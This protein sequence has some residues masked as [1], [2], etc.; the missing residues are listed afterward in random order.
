MTNQQYIRK[1]ALIYERYKDEFDKVSEQELYDFRSEI[2]KAYN[3]IPLREIKVLFVD[4]DPY[5]TVAEL[6]ADVKINKVMRVFSGG[7]NSK[8]LPGMLNPMFHADRKS[9]V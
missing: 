6:T 2:V 9:V 7:S 1:N 3:C 5:K 8:L 4:Y